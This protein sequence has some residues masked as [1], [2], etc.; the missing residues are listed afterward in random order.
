MSSLVFDAVRVSKRLGLL[1]IS[2]L[3]KNREV[4]SP[5][6]ACRRHPTVLIPVEL[7]TADT[8]I[9]AHSECIRHTPAQPL[10]CLPGDAAACQSR[11][12]VD[13]LGLGVEAA[14]TVTTGAAVLHDALSLQRS[15]AVRREKRP[16]SEVCRV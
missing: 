13:P 16:V 15:P 6:L 1:A 10:T 12:W 4:V 9:A 11:A 5:Y 7:G 8:W 14:R 2:H 3:L